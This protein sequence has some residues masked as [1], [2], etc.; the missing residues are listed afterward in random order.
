MAYAGGRQYLALIDGLT[1]SEI[2]ALLADYARLDVTNA[3]SFMPKVNG[4]FVVE[5]GSNSDG[6]W[7]R[8]ADGTQVCS[9]DGPLD[10]YSTGICTHS[11]DYP[12]AFSEIAGVQLTPDSDQA[13]NPQ[14]AYMWAVRTGRSGIS[15]INRVNLIAHMIDGSPMASGFYL[16]S[17]ALAYGQ[18]K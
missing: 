3:F 2:Q 11:W 9:R 13:S 15:I 5:S 12:A 1:D 10:Y 18:W 17:H 8:W 14:Q 7:T 16:W 4:A 6:E